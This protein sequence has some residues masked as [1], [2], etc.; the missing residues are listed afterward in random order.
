M[1][2]CGDLASLSPEQRAIVLAKPYWRMRWFAS[3]L[4]WNGLQLQWLRLSAADA[5]ALPGVREPEIAVFYVTTDREFHIQINELPDRPTLHQATIGPFRY[6]IGPHV[7]WHRF[8]L[9]DDDADLIAEAQRL[10][11]FLDRQQFRDPAR[12]AAWKKGHPD[13][14]LRLRKRCR[15][16]W[17]SA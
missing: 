3:L 5:A 1:F 17:G 13:L 12:R 10:K 4:N 7:G 16:G 2:I 11:P 9:F 8:E 14:V 15:P 6:G